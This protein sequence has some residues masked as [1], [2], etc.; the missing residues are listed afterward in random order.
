MKKPAFFATLAL[1][2]AAKSHARSITTADETS[3]PAGAHV[4]DGA[5]GGGN[6]TRR[7]PTD[8]KKG[9][10]LNDERMIKLPPVESDLI[11]RA[12][13]SE[14]QKKIKKPPPE[15]L[16]LSLRVGASAAQKR[17]WL[18]EELQKNQKKPRFQSQTLQ[19]AVN[20][21]DLKKA[22]AKLK[23][24]KKWYETVAG[25][26]HPL[27]KNIL[28]KLSFSGG[29]KGLIHDLGINTQTVFDKATFLFSAHDLTFEDSYYRALGSEVLQ[30]LNPGVYRKYKKNG[31]TIKKKASDTLVDP[32]AKL[33]AMDSVSYE[34]FMIRSWLLKYF[35][36]DS[37]INEMMEGSEY[38]KVNYHDYYLYEYFLSHDNLPDT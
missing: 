32:K 1:L 19:S 37:T 9:E 8:D 4:D 2:A 28:S 17:K 6:G 24:K 21:E 38:F 22:I 25:T 27:A 5:I 29:L 16:D 20:D 35:L 7:V 15:D 26:L 12:G 10:N 3:A 18:Q 30:R 11:A 13:P 23:E 34:Q 36:D 33:M 31:V 14:A